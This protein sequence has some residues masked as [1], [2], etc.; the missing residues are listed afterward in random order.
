MTKRKVKRGDIY[1]ADLSPVI[2]T[3]WRSSSSDPSK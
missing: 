2:G 1:Y 3:V